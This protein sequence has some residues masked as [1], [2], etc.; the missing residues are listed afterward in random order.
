MVPELTQEISDC[1]RC[2]PIELACD[3]T[4][5]PPAKLLG[6]QGNNNN[7]TDTKR[8]ACIAL[9]DDATRESLIEILDGFFGG[10]KSPG[11]MVQD[12]GSDRTGDRRVTNAKYTVRNHTE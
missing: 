3:G 10:K 8:T 5:T 11:L 4:S 9:K 12:R 2:S 7:T 1:P 6:A